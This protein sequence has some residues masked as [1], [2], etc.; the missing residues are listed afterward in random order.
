M[1]DVPALY[2]KVMAA[3]AKALCERGAGET[4]LARHFKC[5]VWDIRLWRATHKDFESAV[6]V[7]RAAA[8]D[9]VEMA[10]YERAIGT[11][12]E[13]VKR[14]WTPLR[15]E[16]GAVIGKEEHQTVT[17]KIVPA[18]TGAA[19]YWLENRRPEL[20]KN[21]VEVDHTMNNKDIRDIPT[22]ELLRIAA[23]SGPGSAEPDT[24]AVKPRGLH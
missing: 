17:T 18:D 24:R 7:G 8:D 23:G 11:T 3:E 1:S 13:E 12:Y 9:R 2:S 19:R 14:W 4:D 15:D 22:E 6:K 5:T 16:S 10:L 20:W 21:R